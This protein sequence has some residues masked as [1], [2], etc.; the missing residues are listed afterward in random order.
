MLLNLF[1][2]S[3]KNIYL[4]PTVPGTLMLTNIQ[5]RS[6]PSKKP[7]TIA[8]LELDSAY[9]YQELTYFGSSLT[10]ALKETSLFTLSLRVQL[11]LASLKQLPGC[12]IC[13]KTESNILVF[14]RTL[15]WLS[16]RRVI[17]RNYWLLAKFNRMPNIA[18]FPGLNRAKLW[19][20][21]FL[22]RLCWI[23]K[24]LK[25]F[26][27][28]LL[29]TPLTFASKT[30]ATVFQTRLTSLLLLSNWPM[31]VWWILN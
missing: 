7:S 11:V 20:M 17:R 22:G 6:P 24:L 4:L 27:T 12:T 14:C 5:L 10:S 30:D 31:T 3:A 15:V 8:A 19:S 25:S 13:C 29:S 16:V 28:S 9:C 26:R 21:F 18:L 1:P 23:V 2:T